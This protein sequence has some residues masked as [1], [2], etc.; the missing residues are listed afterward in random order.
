[1]QNASRTG[2]DS[3]QTLAEY[4]T[5]VGDRWTQES[6][7]PRRTTGTQPASVFPSHRRSVIFRSG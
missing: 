5:F 6:T 4:V 2:V 3:T 1:M 7:T